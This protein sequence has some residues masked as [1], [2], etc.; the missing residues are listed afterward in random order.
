[1][2]VSYTKTVY[3]NGTAPPRNETNLNNT[4]VGVE[5]VV[6][7]ANQNETDIAGKLDDVVA[8]TNVTIDKT[9]PNNPIISSTASGG[10]VSTFTELTDTPADYVGNEGKLVKVNA[11]ADG[12]I[13]GDP[14]GT[15]VSW[16]DISGTLSDQTDLQGALDVKVDSVVAGTGI[17]VD[18]TDPNN[19]IITNTVSAYDDT[20]IQAEVDANTADRHSHTN[21]AVLDATTASFTI[22]DETKLDGLSNYDD[23]AI[24]VALDDKANTVTTG[25]PVGFIPVGNLGIISEA[26]YQAGVAVGNTIY[27][28]I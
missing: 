19:P 2:A 10:G 7:L 21:E 17:T 1:M 26:D 24:L 27:F 25:E 15:T 6:A 9:D 13:Y 12:L 16:G 18:A 23:S 20:A 28:R 11:T 5:S 22:A 8:G 3:V 14:S 4:E